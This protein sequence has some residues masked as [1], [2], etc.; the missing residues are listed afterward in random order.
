[1]S[2]HHLFVYIFGISKTV[3]L[4]QCV[5]KKT[6]ATD[7]V[8]KGN[9]VTAD[10]KKRDSKLHQTKTLKGKSVEVADIVKLVGLVAFIVVLVVSG[11][12]AWP[13]ISDAFADGGV[14]GVISRVQDAGAFGVIILLLMQVLQ[15]IVA[16]IPGEVMQIAAGLLYGSVGGT[17]LVLAGA[18]IASVLVMLLVRK[19]GAPFLRAMVSDEHMDK[20]R[21]FELSGKLN[22][23]V[24]VLFLI[25][26]LPKDLFTYLVGITDMPIK[27]FV[28]LTT[29]ARIP[30]VFS[31]AY[32]A[33]SIADGD[34]MKGVV[35]F[36]VTAAV[37]AIGLLAKNRI[38]HV[39]SRRKKARNK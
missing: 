18:A 12:V 23:I 9:V 35:V 6:M 19:L 10:D 20:F 22:A 26:G 33:S 27:T 28:L 4:R 7:Y 29:V 13:I 15:V 14:D 30:G 17:V 36:G 38:M 16:F 2:P 25:P 39:L 1:M 8:A 24:F 31:S 5:E 37:A 34:V 11:G 3:E 32:A 21:R